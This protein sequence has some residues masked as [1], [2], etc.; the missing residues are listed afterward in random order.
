[1]VRFVFFEA[2]DE[3]EIAIYDSNNAQTI[4]VS[5]EKI[6]KKDLKN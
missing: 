1:M 4:D 2:D 3:Y 6:A 5:T